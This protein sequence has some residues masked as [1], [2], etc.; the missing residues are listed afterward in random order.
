MR[1][2]API[3]SAAMSIGAASII[4]SAVASTLHTKIGRRFQVIPGA[5]MVM[6]V[7]IRF[8]PSR[9]IDTPTSAKKPMYAS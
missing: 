6:M 8:K 9:H 3:S 2:N 1:S 4:S 5:R 7:T